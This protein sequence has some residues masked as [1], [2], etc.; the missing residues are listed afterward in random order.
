MPGVTED[1][2][3]EVKLVMMNDSYS[4]LMLTIISCIGIPGNMM[5]LIV[6][7]C[8]PEMRHKVFNMFIVHQSAI[9]LLGCVGTLLLQYFNDVNAP[10]V[11]KG[12]R[13]CN[14][15]ILVFC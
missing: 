1:D 5:V 9:D 15:I 7:L 3:S 11:G 12:M 10:K 8:S 2:E 13:M 4:Q 14:I 6:I